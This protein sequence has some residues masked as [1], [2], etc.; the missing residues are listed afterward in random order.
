MKKSISI[1]IL[2]A[3][4]M[5]K[6]NAQSTINCMGGAAVLN[7]NT[8]EVSIGEMSIVSTSSNGGVHLTQGVLQK[9]EVKTLS[10]VNNSSKIKADV[11]PNPTSDIL[12]IAYNLDH[13]SK[14]SLVIFDHSGK[15]I[16]EELLQNVSGNSNKQIDLSRFAAGVYTLHLQ[17]HTNDAQIYQ[18][19]HQI[20]KNE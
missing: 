13:S 8:Y 18:S 6:S 4:I 19:T 2:Y 16:L 10:I 11:F 9:I 17:L 5:N 15:K 3:S 12:N 20:V 7:G 1:L 14:S